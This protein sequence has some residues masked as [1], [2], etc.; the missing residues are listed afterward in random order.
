MME[1]WGEALNL[2]LDKSIKL[3]YT[4][5]IIQYTIIYFY[6]PPTVMI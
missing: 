6:L 1:Y 4:I 2:I 5:Y 3:K